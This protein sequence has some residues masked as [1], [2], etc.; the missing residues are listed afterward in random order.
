[1]KKVVKCAVIRKDGKHLFIQRAA[2]DSHGGYW[3]TAGGGVDADDLSL[4]DAC[5]REVEEETGVKL[6]Q[7]P[8]YTGQIILVDDESGESFETHLFTA[9]VED[10]IVDLSDN[11]DHQNFIW[12]KPTMKGDIVLD[13]WTLK[14]YENI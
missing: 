6:D 10:P 4:A 8:T 5:I 11:L 13:S 1:M 3:E 2:K 7:E 12:L 9:H 14:Q